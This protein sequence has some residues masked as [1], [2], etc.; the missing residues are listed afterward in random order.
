MKLIRNP[1][2][3]KGIKEPIQTV[4]RVLASQNNCDGEPYDQM[5]IAANYIDQLERKI[6]KLSKNRKE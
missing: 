2:S 4:L 5:Q 1:L 6:E 3:V